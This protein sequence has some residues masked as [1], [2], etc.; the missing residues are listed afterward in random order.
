MVVVVVVMVV[1]VV[2]C[3][4]KLAFGTHTLELS[5]TNTKGKRLGSTRVLGVSPKGKAGG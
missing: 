5:T 2:V 3:G 4:G 1:V